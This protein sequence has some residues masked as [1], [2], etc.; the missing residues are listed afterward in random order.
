MK[1]KVELKDKVAVITGGGGILCSVMAK[2]LAKAGAKVAI[3]DL[4]A[5]AAESVAAEIVADG[6][7]AIGLSANVLNLPVSK[8]PKPKSAK[9]SVPVTFLST[10]PA[11][12]IP[13]VLPARSI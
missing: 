2:A 9:F 10:V 8:L 7:E 1:M 13:K 4:R 6:G 3:L 5:E 11:A 12:T